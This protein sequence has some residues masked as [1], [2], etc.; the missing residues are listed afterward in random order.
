MRIIGIS[1]S[2]RVGGNTDLILQTALTAAK[3]EGADV[4]LI[5]ITSYRLQPCNACGTC[6]SA[7]R[8]VIDDDGEKI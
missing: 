5:R 4:K 2:P 3:E 7:K 6:F 8:C 1:G